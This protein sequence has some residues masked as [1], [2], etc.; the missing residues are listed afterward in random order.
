MKIAYRI[1]HIV[2]RKSQ[3]M[4]VAILMVTAAI[5]ATSIAVISLGSAQVNIASGK[6]QSTQA[7][8]IAEACL[9]D[10]LMRMARK[11]IAYPY[12]GNFTYSTGSCTISV[13]PA[14]PYTVTSTATVEK[15]KRQIVVTASVSNEVLTINSWEESY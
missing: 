13:S 12:S 6:K 14:S 10:V 3:A 2:N 11:D 8:S 5:L 9:E 1:S 15:T 7:Y 4:L